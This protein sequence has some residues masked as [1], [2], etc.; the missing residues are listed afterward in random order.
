MRVTNHR[1]M[2]ILAVADVWHG[3]NAHAFVRAFRRMGHS[4]SVVPSETFIPGA[5]QSTPLRALR[6]LLEPRLVREY[7]DALVE[8]ARRLRPHLFFVFKG[9]YVAPEAVRAIREMGA[10]AVNFYPDVSFLAH[11]AYLPRALPLYDWVFTTKTFGV[12]DMKQQLGLRSVSFLPHGYD[13]EVHAPVELADSDRVTYECDVSFIGTWSPKKQAILERV[14]SEFPDAKIR[15]WGEQWSHARHS[16]GSVIEGR[17]V[18]GT[19]YAKALVASRVN[20]AIL[21]EARTGASSGD[22]IT[23][24][25]FH[26]PATGAFMLHERTDELAEYFEE[27]VECASFGNHDELVEKTA[28]YLD[29]GEEREAVAAAGRRRSVESGYSVDERARAVLDKALALRDEV[30]ERALS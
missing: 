11:G 29:H 25:T 28:Y 21:S 16:L 26:I 15:I 20:L 9:R 7:A 18:L 13:P 22:K 5:W 14:V 1:P 6:R 17:G 8:E 27:G 2:R 10:V 23:S 24:R 12:D 4:V 19:E 3:S 30:K